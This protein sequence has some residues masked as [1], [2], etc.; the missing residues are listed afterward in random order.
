MQEVYT[1]VSLLHDTAAK[2]IVAIPIIDLCLAV[3][4]MLGTRVAK[5]WR[6]QE[7]LDL[8]GMLTAAQEVKHTEGEGD[9][10]RTDMDTD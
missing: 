1:Y 4:R 5:R 7:G 3:E 9:T 6:D 10:D 2:F 8:E